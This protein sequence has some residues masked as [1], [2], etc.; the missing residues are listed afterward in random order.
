MSAQRTGGG[1]SAA[2]VHHLWE[3]GLLYFAGGIPWL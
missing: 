1:G 2:G 3:P